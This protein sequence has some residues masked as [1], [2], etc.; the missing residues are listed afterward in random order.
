MSQN[1]IA[2][3]K[4]NLIICAVAVVIIILGFLLMTGP[5][6]TFEGGFETDI[7][8]AR[9]IKLAPIVCLIGFVLMIVGILYPVKENKK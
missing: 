8:S 7:F 9:R 5:A 4:K 6:T 3:S 2:L 1:N